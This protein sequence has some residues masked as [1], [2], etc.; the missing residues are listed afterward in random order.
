MPLKL[1][2]TVILSI[3]AAS[4]VRVGIDEL[5]GGDA[6]LRINGPIGTL[7]I[8]P[9][10]LAVVVR[11]WR[12]R[13]PV[14]P[15]LG[16]EATLFFAEPWLEYG[17]MVVLA[18]CLLVASALGFLSSLGSRFELCLDSLLLVLGA[19]LLTHKLRN[20]RARLLLS[21]SGMICSKKRPT[22]V[23]W[24][25]VKGLEMSSQPWSTDIVVKFSRSGVSSPTPEVESIK[26][27]PTL[28]GVE[29]ASLYRAIETRRTLFTF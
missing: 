21:P 27:S 23:S 24:D 9:A 14:P 10:L 20:G 6:P 11:F 2:G 12:R 8:A 3:M 7:L 5:M 28:L 25:R 4:A 19:S 29:P 26:V 18:I 16:P 22:T 13:S 17:A 15:G 1:W